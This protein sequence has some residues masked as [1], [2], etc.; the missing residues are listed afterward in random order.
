MK[1]PD[2]AAA[3]AKFNYD[4]RIPVEHRDRVIS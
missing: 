2:G 3:D 1:E 4:D